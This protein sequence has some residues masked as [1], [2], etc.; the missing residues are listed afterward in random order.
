LIR[1]ALQHLPGLGP[2]RLKRLAEAGIGDW[3]SLRDNPAAAR[4]GPAGRDRLLAAIDVCE[5][6]V[7][8]RDYRFLTR[9]F[10]A[11]DQWRILGAFHDD[12]AYFDIETSGLDVYS[13]VTLIA[14]EYQGEL[15]TF[16]FNENLDEFLDLVEEV[17]MLVSFNGA[18][19]DVPRVLQQFHIPELRCGHIDLRWM[20][21]HDKLRGGLK[22]IERTLDIARP[23]DLDGVSGEDAVMLWRLWDDRE[24][25]GARELLLRYCCADV[26]ALRLLAARLLE[27]KACFVECPP[28]ADVWRALDALPASPGPTLQPVARSAAPV[29]PIRQRLERHWQRRRGR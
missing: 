13:H 24:H 16:L 4:L 22:E 18:S 27:A 2:E 6:A 14:A 23:S 9:A 1:G 8:E 3:L 11:R 28:P 15:R 20:C 12:V 5:Q 26:L 25:R 19:F 29:D 21:Y 7:L 10:A 17:G